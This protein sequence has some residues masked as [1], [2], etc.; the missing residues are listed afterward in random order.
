MNLLEKVKWDWVRKN[1]VIPAIS[2][3]GT[4]IA[5]YLVGRGVAPDQAEIVAAACAV[6]GGVVWDFV[7]DRIMR[8]QAA[9]TGKP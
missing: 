1:L 8:V 2:R 3:L 9:Q 5:A 4:F 7:L 6:V